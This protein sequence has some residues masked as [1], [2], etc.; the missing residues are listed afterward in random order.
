MFFLHNGRRHRVR[1][2]DGPERIEREWWLDAG[3]ARDY[4]RVE[5]EDG[6]RYWL[7]RSDP[8]KDVIWG[9]LLGMRLP[10]IA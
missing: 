1:K 9:E 7:F 3:D 2:A 8:Y 6:G 4:F 10:R 5:D